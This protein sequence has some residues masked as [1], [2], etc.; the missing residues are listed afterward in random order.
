MKSS[1][2]ELISSKNDV[3][4]TDNDKIN[5]K[6]AILKTMNDESINTYF[7]LLARYL[8]AKR[9]KNLTSN[10]IARL[11]NFPKMTILRFENL[12]TIPQ[13]LTLIKILNTVGLK[14]TL[15]D[16]ADER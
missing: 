5:V 1:I 3:R 6:S 12:Q 14:L 4:L 8:E 15:E 16:E 10:D 11:S 9:Q 7:N 2:E 13:T